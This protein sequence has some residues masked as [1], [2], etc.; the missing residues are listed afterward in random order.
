[1]T[2]SSLPRSARLGPAPLATALWF[3]L[4]IVVFNVR[5]DWQVRI[6]GRA[7]V[8]SQIARHQ[9]GLPTLSINEA[10]RPMVGSAAREA[11]LWP[12][13]IAAA[14]TAAIAAASRGRHA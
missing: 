10:F 9:Q 11:A 13:L 8:R 2:A 4:A 12:A 5:F 6:A 1:M 3:V 14:G 7:F